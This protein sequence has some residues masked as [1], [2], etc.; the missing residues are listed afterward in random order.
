[1]CYF[2]S[3]TNI[4]F[5]QFSNNF[6]NNYNGINTNNV[7]N[8][9]PLN[10]NP[11]PIQQQSTPLEV[12]FPNYIAQL[13]QTTSELASLNQQQTINMLKE[14]LQF[15]KNFE[16]LLTQLL[17]D[18]QQSNTQNLLLLLSSCLDLS[19]LSSLL[20][21]NSKE[22]LTNLYQML[23]QYN[24][25]G[26]SIKDE[27]LN[28]FTKLIS[29]ISASSSSDIQSLK[30]VMQMYLPWL[31]LTDPN[32]FKLEISSSGTN[33]SDSSDDFVTILISTENFG[34]L[35]TN[36]YKTD[37]DGIKIDLISSETFPQ[38][39]FTILMKEES[40]KYN[41]NINFD[42]S[43]K[44]VFNKDKKEKS[45]M[46]ICMNTSP[47]VN[48]FLILISNAVIKNVHIIDS[49]ENLKEQRKEKVQNG[50]S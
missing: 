41:I 10:N 48:M 33:G 13:Q 6:S 7:Q 42:L 38:K 36:I 21:T 25:I 19:K 44:E 12:L 20:Q 16:Q 14:L 3:M 31:P 1:M 45:D 15:P 5:N 11:A 23:A 9:I 47:G 50:E 2:I 4:N 46:Q 28:Q 17:S 34:N 26:V 35:Q 40:V 37:N 30:T 8:N 49:K 29:L 22:A 27:Q 32:A 18:S 43:Q 24:Q 39:E